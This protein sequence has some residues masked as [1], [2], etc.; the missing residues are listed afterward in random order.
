MIRI[1]MENGKVIELQLDAAAEGSLMLGGR[2]G[3]V[4]RRG[5]H[6]GTAQGVERPAEGLPA[7]KR[8]AQNAKGIGGSPALGA[9]GAFDQTGARV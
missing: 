9:I 6:A 8:R 3:K 7:D 2:G 4:Y 5:L 1:T